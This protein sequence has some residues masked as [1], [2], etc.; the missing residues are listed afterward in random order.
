MALKSSIIYSYKVKVF[1]QN[2]M[3][4]TF[5]SAVI[6]PYA[7]IPH[8][9]PLEVRLRDNEEIIGF[10]KCW[11]KELI[12][13]TE[14]QLRICYV[15]GIQYTLVALTQLWRLS[16]RKT[17]GSINY[18]A[19][20]GSGTGDQNDVF[21]SDSNWSYYTNAPIFEQS[22]LVFGLPFDTYQHHVWWESLVSV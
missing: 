2:D 16:S 18:A 15:Y 7:M 1:F 4:T 12:E 22:S 21:F 9:F 8:N 3:S 5:S 10:G 14:R 13:F 11:E 20:D 19:G 17:F 6:F